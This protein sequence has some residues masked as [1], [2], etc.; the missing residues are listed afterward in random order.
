MTTDEIMRRLGEVEQVLALIGAA[1][2][3]P[4]IKFHLG[5]FPY[6][7]WQ[8]NHEAWAASNAQELESA[9]VRLELASIR[10]NAEVAKYKAQL[11]LYRAGQ[12]PFSE[13]IYVMP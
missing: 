3:K 8:A 2:A 5:P 9:K 4:P 12:W 10:V 11:A 1:L 6:G 13:P 7:P